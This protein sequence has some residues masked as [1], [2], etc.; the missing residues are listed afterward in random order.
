MRKNPRINEF[1]DYCETMLF[2][3]QIETK[4]LSWS[5]FI[6][7]IKLN[8]LQAGL[9]VSKYTPYVPTTTV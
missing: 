3:K 8:A 6:I 9:F 4:S 5:S 1:S 7:H 2:I